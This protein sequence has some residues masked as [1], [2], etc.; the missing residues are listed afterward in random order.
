MSSQMS[1]KVQ[2]QIQQLQQVQQQLQTVLSQK[3]Q[4]RDRDPRD[5]AGR[6]G[7]RRPPRGI[8]GLPVC[9]DRDDAEAEGGCFGLAQGEGRDPRAPGQA[10]SSGRSRC[11][12]AGSRPCRTRSSR[13]SRAV[14]AP[15]AWAAGWGSGADPRPPDPFFHGDGRYPRRTGV[16]SRDEARRACINGPAPGAYSACEVWRLRIAVRSGAGPIRPL[17]LSGA[18]QAGP[19]LRPYPGERD[20]G[21]GLSPHAASAD[22]PISLQRGDRGAGA[23]MVLGSELDGGIGGRARPE[24]EVEGGAAIDLALGPASSAVPF[25]DPPDER[26]ADPRPLVLPRV[27]EPGEVVEDAGRVPRRGNPTPLSA[28]V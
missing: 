28:T 25:D 15:A 1:P 4:Y 2:N 11:S 21:A 3:A 19:G 18:L 8:D 27:V 5:P 22:T 7:A 20:D 10:G 14:P 6:R 17:C 24:R 12:R 9:R 23:P 16:L 13:R 26:E